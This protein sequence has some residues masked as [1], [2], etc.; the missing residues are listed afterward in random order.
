MKDLEKN[1]FVIYKTENGAINVNAIL[2]D[3]T[4]W[5]TQKGMSELFDVGIPAI[6]KHIN[7]I[8]E[9]EELQ[10]NMVVSK[11]EITTEHGAI[12][13]KT[14][15]KLTNFYNLDMIIAVG[16][17]VNSKAATKFRQWATDVLKE[18]IIKGYKLDKER[19]KNGPKFGKD[20]FRDLLTEIKEIRT[21]EY[22]VYRQILDIF[23]AT[24]IDY[25]KTS[26]EAYTFFKIVQNK[27]H[28]AI[29]GKTAAELIY[30]RV[31][32]QKENMGL[33]TWK[34]APDGKILKYD[35]SIAKNY[36]NNEELKRL[37]D[38]TN[39][40]FEIAEE[41]TEKEIIFKMKDWINIIDDLLKYR[42]KEILTGSGKV[43]NKMAV[44]K[45]H[46]EYEIFKVMQD[47]EYISGMDTLYE[48][49]LKEEDN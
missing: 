23:E 28:Y 48:K 40:F 16:Y 4:I 30:E 27:L 38:L 8:F 32:N 10:E 21:S 1:K 33:T 15:T 34:K 46:K 11:M 9:T 17:R 24:S 29:T 20:Y 47:E 45:A 5:L 35:V 3:E 19:L 37:Q 13:D 12:S 36:L 25:D 22:R 14:Q 44:E 42:K 41:E 49:Y 18:Y 31:N 7:N 43:S 2:K 39:L 6:S 26:E